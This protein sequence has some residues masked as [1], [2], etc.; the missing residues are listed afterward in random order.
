VRLLF[1]PGIVGIWSAASAL[2]GPLLETALFTIGAAALG[3]WALGV[4]R[5]S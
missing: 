3:I 2:G 4:L 1:V 5:G